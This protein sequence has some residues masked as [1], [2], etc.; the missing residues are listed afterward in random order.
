M[1]TLDNW[2]QVVVSCVYLEYLGMVDGGN[3]WAGLLAIFA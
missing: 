3:L 2:P 1:V